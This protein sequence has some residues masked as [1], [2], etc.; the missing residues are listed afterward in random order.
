MHQVK[1]DTILTINNYLNEGDQ[2]NLEGNLEKAI[3]KY[4]AALQIE[5]NFVPALNQLAEIYKSQK[6][7]DQAISYYQRIIKLKPENCQ[8][9]ATLAAIFMRQGKIREA[10]DAYQKAISL[11]PEQPASVYIGWGDA[12]SK[13]GQIE[14]A[15]ATYQKAIKINSSISIVHAKLAKALMTQK[16][17]QDAIRA[18][19]QAISLQPEQPSWV[20]RGWGNALKQNGQLDEA[21]TAYQRVIK[22]SPD[23]PKSYLRVAQ[24]YSKKGQWHEAI[25]KYHQVLLL[26]P[27]SV[28]VLNQLATIYEKL[29]FQPA[30]EILNHNDLLEKILKIYYEVIE[31]NCNKAESYFG[32]G[33][34]LLAQKNWEEAID[35]FTETLK[36]NPHWD[37]V[38][39]SLAYALKQQVNENS[40]DIRHCYKKGV[41]PEK[42]LKKIYTFKQEDLITSQDTASDLR[43]IKV[44]EVEPFLPQKIE[45]NFVVIL[46]NGRADINLV[47][48]PNDAVITSNNKLVQEVS[49]TNSQLI[50]YAN[51]LIQPLEFEE[52]LA[53]FRGA[54]GSNYYHW[55]LQVIPQFC[56]LRRVGIKTETIEKFAFF[57]LPIHI[58]FKM[59][60]LS[61][62]GI[63]QSKIIETFRN[64][65]IKAKK[66]IV[67]SPINIAPP[68]KLACELVRSE[69]LNKN[70]NKKS[71]QSINKSNRIY[72]SRKNA[73]YRKVINENQLINLLNN[74][75]FKTFYLE[76][77]SF[78]E[79]VDLFS[80]A[81]IIVAP[82]G[83]GL[84]NLIFCSLG[85]KIIEIFS[86]DYTPSMYQIISSYY[87]LNYYCIIAEGIENAKSKYKARDQHLK[88]NLNSL[89]DL[90]KL[91]EII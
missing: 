71:L 24:L 85:T 87:T 53:Y 56:L 52:T 77:M 29:Y 19:Q 43:Y 15:V 66:L 81:E 5:P 27:E 25:Q 28:S 2:L 26:M 63:P 49:G 14:E 21:I 6:K 74:F 82:H 44:K 33:L 73:S 8:I 31:L 40:P 90:M 80:K 59:Q 10:I 60:T 20:Y 67:T 35:Y 11:Q 86:K 78:L 4:S 32:I 89:L 3:E 47:N 75:G 18:Y 37:K 70:L 88:V 51:K 76:S 36:R 84:T 1:S 30:Q 16:N 91:A 13:N 9:R 41:L 62:L 55:M 68:R 65:H 69:F 7:F 48:N 79:Q 23:N 39:K 12:L 34:I 46:T 54:A 38:Y 17:I 50:F 58:P 61:L 22:F 83:A 45:N 57:R 42:I 72:I 64:P